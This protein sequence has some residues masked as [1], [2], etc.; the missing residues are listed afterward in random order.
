[1][2]RD[3]RDKWT[4]YIHP[5]KKII[6]AEEARYWKHTLAKIL[7]IGLEFE[8]KGV[9]DF[10]NWYRIEEICNEYVKKLLQGNK[11]PTCGTIIPNGANFCVSCGEKM[12]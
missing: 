7:K 5:S 8:Y 3:N 9:N 11:C 1:M 12:P 6:S 2:G 4:F 10:R